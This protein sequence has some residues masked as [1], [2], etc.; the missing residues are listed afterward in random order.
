M[1][2]CDGSGFLRVVRTSDC[3][4]PR[5]CRLLGFDSGLAALIGR[6][7]NLSRRVGFSKLDVGCV[8]KRKK[9]AGSRLGWTV[10]VVGLYRPI[11]GG[12]QFY[13]AASHH[14]NLSFTLPSHVISI[15]SIDLDQDWPLIH[16]NLL[17]VLS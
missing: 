5:V 8:K 14:Y 16:Q 7:P 1:R 15:R 11:V 10:F 12:V 4:A 6:F 17:D 3:L 2:R 13:P 9:P